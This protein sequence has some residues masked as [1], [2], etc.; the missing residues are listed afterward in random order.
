MFMELFFPLETQKPHN[1][2]LE[3]SKVWASIWRDWHRW[4]FNVISIKY[5]RLKFNRISTVSGY[6]FTGLYIPT[7]FYPSIVDNSFFNRE[8]ASLSLVLDQFM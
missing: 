3:I 8:E 2:T 4:S 6:A 5:S 1:H 7:S